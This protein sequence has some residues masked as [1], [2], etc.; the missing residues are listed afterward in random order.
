MLD[1]QLVLA[2]TPWL[3]YLCTVATSA[4]AVAWPPPVAA[5]YTLLAPVSFGY[6]RTLPA[7]GNASVLLA[8]LDTIY[9]I[10]LG[11]VVLVIISLLR[12]AAAT[13]DEAQSRAL[14]RYTQ[15][16][17]QHARDVERVEVDS[18]VH[19]NVLATLLAAAGATTPQTAALAATMARQSIERL[20]V[21]VLPPPAA[22]V[23]PLARFRSRVQD[24]L[25]TVATPI[26]FQGGPVADISLPAAVGEALFA[27]TAQAIV[28]SVQHAA[29]APHRVQPP[30][31]DA[32]WPSE[33]QALTDA[34]LQRTVSI[35]GD[36]AGGV[37]IVISDQ[38]VGF[39]QAA[40]PVE[41]LGL[42]VSIVERVAAVGGTTTVRSRPGRGTSIKIFWRAEPDA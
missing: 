40:V 33:P 9:A 11:F 20:G 31:P 17:R 14:G 22:E 7:G 12:R 28:N 32:V 13:V 35:A 2:G 15:A 8:T 16:V 24:F 29:A 5:G 25:A 10:L 36:S 34:E 21:A 23:V 39:D 27:A 6:L 37:T 26:R 3:W 38:G 19:D 30:T 41:R 4:A 1:P 42:R 18:L